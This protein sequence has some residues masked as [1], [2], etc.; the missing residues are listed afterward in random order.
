MDRPAPKIPAPAPNLPVD[1]DALP[2]TPAQRAKLLLILIVLPVL[3]VSLPTVLVTC[4][5]GRHPK[6]GGSGGIVAEV[7]R[8][9]GRHPKEK[10]FDTGGLHDALNHTAE[11]SLPTPAALVDEPVRLTSRPE[12]LNARAERVAQLAKYYG[13]QANEFFASEGEKHFFVELP[14]GLGTTFRRSLLS[15]ETTPAANDTPPVAAISTGIK[16]QVEV[17]IRV[18]QDE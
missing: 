2:P 16:D 12:R 15:G 8:L 3:A 6:D 17:F 13:G 14:P 7:G 1:A 18:N 4:V 10:V 11:Q 9:F 5:F